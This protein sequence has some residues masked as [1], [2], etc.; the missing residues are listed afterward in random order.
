MTTYAMSDSN[1]ASFPALTKL[2]VKNTFT[3][4]NATW[5]NM[6]LASNP[7]ANKK[8]QQIFTE[9]DIK[10]RTQVHM[11]VDH[12][13]N[14]Q[15][16][17]AANLR[18][19]KQ[20]NLIPKTN[21]VGI[22]AD[23]Y[24]T[25]EQVALSASP[26][27]CMI[28]VM[29]AVDAKDGKRFLIFNHSGIFGAFLQSALSAIR[30]AHSYYDFA[31]HDLEVFIYPYISGKHFIKPLEG[32]PMVAEFAQQRWQPFVTPMPD[33]NTVAIDW[34]HLLIAELKEAGITQIHKTGLDTYEQHEV[35]KLYSHTYAKENV[36]SEDFRFG[37]IASI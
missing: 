10:N 3:Y 5:G 25:K 8:Y 26:A 11:Q 20:F 22:K 17:T 28:I 2:G 19:Y 23:S 24:I 14:C 29:T 9:L 27:D 12:N 15:L 13:D 32:N 31:D 35:G 37:V 6:S 30:Q 16:L 36:P 33:D 7:E 18:I 1:L 4:D 34:G 21:I